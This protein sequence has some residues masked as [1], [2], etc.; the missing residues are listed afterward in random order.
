MHPESHRV[1]PPR[2]HHLGWRQGRH[3]C[4]LHPLRPKLPAFAAPPRGGASSPYRRSG[5]PWAR[6]FQGHLRTQRSQ[7]DHRGPQ[8]SAVSGSFLSALVSDLS[9]WLIHFSP[10]T[11]SSSQFL[12]DKNSA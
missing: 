11:S 3:T 9:S 8:G 10:A 2:G 6:E 12:G 1:G 7:R 4:T 5:A